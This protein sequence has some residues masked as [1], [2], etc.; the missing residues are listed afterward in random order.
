MQVRPNP[1]RTWMIALA[2][3]YAFVWQVVAQGPTGRVAE[4]VEQ[5]QRRYDATRDLVAEVEQETT[6]AK[7]GRTVRAR[8]TVLFQKPGK[9]RWEMRNSTEEVIVADGTTLWIYRP[10]DQQVIRMPFAHAFRSST[11]ISFLT[12]VGRIKDD[13]E[14]QLG[15]PQGDTLVLVLVPKNKGAAEVG[16]LR[17]LVDAQTFD[18]VGAEVEDALGNLSRLRLANARRNVGVS[19]ETFRFDPPPG[20]DVLDAP[21]AQE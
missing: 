7:L 5:V 11:P 2:S 9:M 14:A 19:A 10:E 20:V 6:M 12:G 4:V 18:I 13:F 1:C 8:G 17:L 3:V 16:T 21:G 15:N